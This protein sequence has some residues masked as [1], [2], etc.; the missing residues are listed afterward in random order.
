M[1]ALPF[2]ESLFTYPTLDY[3]MDMVE[4]RDLSEKERNFFQEL[5]REI[6]IK[7]QLQKRYFRI[8]TE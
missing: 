4:E 5:M 8:G 7:M 6:E 1:L 2:E 3:I